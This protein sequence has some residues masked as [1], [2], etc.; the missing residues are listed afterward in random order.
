MISSGG[1]AL[2]GASM[3]TALAIVCGPGLARS[4]EPAAKSGA[5]EVVVP[6]VAIY[7][8]DK[9]REG[10]LTTKVIRANG[11]VLSAV[12]KSRADLEGRV[13]RRTLVPGQPITKDAVRAFHVVTQGQRVSIQF[14]SESISILMT[15][16]AIQPGGVGDV[17][18]VRNTDT[19]RLVRARIT[20]AGM[21][22]VVGP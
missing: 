12:F 13:A 22:T 7:P 3:A 19:G 4:A 20:D 9:I 14:Q 5:V 2:V 15:G 1:L 17:I 6:Q 16:S 21:L 10:L 18:S 11:A 8:G